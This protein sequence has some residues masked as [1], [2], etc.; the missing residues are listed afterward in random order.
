MT[1]RRAQHAL[2]ARVNSLQQQPRPFKT[3]QEVRAAPDD[4]N[5]VARLARSARSAAYTARGDKVLQQMEGLALDP[6][7]P[8]TWVARRL[9]EGISATTLTQDVSAARQAAQTKD[10]PTRDALHTQVLNDVLAAARRLTGPSPLQKG[11]VP[12]T[13]EEYEVM[14][15]RG[16]TKFQQ[17]LALCWLRAARTADTLALRQGSLW[18]RDQHH[19]CIELGS[20]KTRKLGLPGYLT[21]FLPTREREILRPLISKTP[22]KTAPLTREPLL[23]TTYKEF[24]AN[25]LRYRPAGSR[26]TPH[27]LRKGAVLRM[28]KS[29]ARL[30]DVA[31]VTQHRTTLGVMAYTSLPDTQ[32]AARMTRASR[33]ITSPTTQ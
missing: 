19:L 32:T 8:P 21:V 13:A 9:R 11:A 12:L 17:T 6:M 29:G 27:S 14:I 3:L 2:P 23:V 5:L 16:D 10:R 28:I 24:R 25:F 22:P 18:L 30:R 31:L 7:I 20:E 15:G 1:T 33:A 26:V 4:G